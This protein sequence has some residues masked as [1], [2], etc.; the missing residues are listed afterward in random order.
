MRTIIVELENVSSEEFEIGE[1]WSIAHIDMEL[2]KKYGHLGW[3]GWKYKYE[4]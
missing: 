1:Y 2:D 4:T 3:L